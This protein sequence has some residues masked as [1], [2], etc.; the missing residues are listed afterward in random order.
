MV[1]N[2]DDCRRVACVTRGRMLAD[3]AVTKPA[4]DE[5]SK[6]VLGAVFEN[7]AMVSGVAFPSSSS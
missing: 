7:A 3:N 2:E 4:A 5:R 1:V 6:I